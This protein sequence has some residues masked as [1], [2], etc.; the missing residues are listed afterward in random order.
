MVTSPNSTRLKQKSHCKAPIPGHH[1]LLVESQWFFTGSRVS[2]FGK[3]SLFGRILG[4]LIQ[5]SSVPG[6]FLLIQ[7]VYVLGLLNLVMMN[8]T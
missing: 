3:L 5:E 8:N 2:I 1:Q 6:L 4:N 7:L